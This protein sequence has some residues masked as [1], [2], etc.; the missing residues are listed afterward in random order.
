PLDLRKECVG[1]GP[2]RLAIGGGSC[3]VRDSDLGIA[4]VGSHTSQRLDRGHDEHLW[5]NGRERTLGLSRGRV[6]TKTRPLRHL[7]GSLFNVLEL[8]RPF[9]LTGLL[10]E[11]AGEA[12]TYHLAAPQSRRET[13]ADAGRVLADVHHGLLDDNDV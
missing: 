10:S 9:E 1:A 12:K 7:F 5:R 11:V 4:C 3:Q 8:T 2:Q 13:V 6:R